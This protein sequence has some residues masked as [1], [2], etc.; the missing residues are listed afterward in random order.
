MEYCLANMWRDQTAYDRSLQTIA[1]V[2]VCVCGGGGGGILR[3]ILI[4]K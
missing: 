1:G 3:R 4:R 2:C